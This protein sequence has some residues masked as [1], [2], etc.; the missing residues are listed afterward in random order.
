MRNK[1]AKF[2]KHNTKI[3]VFFVIFVI[4]IILTSFV[5]KIV[6]IV[7]QS[8]F[9]GNSH[10]T[11]SVSNNKELKIL[12]FSPKTQSMSILNLEGEVKN[13]NINKFFAIHLDG[14]VEAEFLDINKDESDLMSAV[15]L[16]FGSAK[17][18][19]TIVDIFR[20]FLASKTIPAKNVAT[21]DISTK[22]DG[23]RVD[24]IVVELLSDREIEKEDQAIEIINATSVTGLGSR[25]GRFVTNMGGKVVQVS[26]ES[27]YQKKSTIL[28]NGDK[29]YTVEK[30][31]KVLG[32]E[33]TQTDRE[34]IGDI[35]III[36]E[37]HND[38]TSF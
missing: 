23:D 27:V 1:K 7:E 14:F 18:D 3:A 22:L 10:F 29:T 28:Y 34:S 12:S 38:S 30:L 2:E 25:L 11:V 16:S 24:K 36:G 33:L 8:K 13:L 15:L 20:L 5:L 31:H 4:L 26:T 6:Q 37:D 35:T 17:T 19:L 9:D 21:L 32:F